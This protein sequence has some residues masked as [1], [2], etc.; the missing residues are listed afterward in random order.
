MKVVFS[1]MLRSAMVPLFGVFAL[2]AVMTGC[3]KS[4][5]PTA[6]GLDELKFSFGLNIVDQGNGTV[7]LSWSGMNNEKDF[8][9]YNVYGAKSD[10][11]VSLEGSTIK[12][13]DDKGD[14][15][16]A[17]KASLAKMGY[18]GKDWET[19]APAT[20]PDGD[21]AIYPYYTVTNGTD[22]VLPSCM[23]KTG[24]GAGVACDAIAAEGGASHVFNGSTTIDM[25]G[26]KIGSNYC[27][28]TLSTLDDGKKVA[29]TTSEVRCV[30][31]RAAVADVAASAAVSKAFAVDLDG[32][33]K[34]CGT[35]G[36]A[37]CGSLDVTA[38]ALANTTAVSFDA[39]T[40]CNATTTVAA[41]IEYFGAASAK[42]ANFTAGKNTGVQDLG[43]Y[44]NGFDDATLPKAPKLS[45]FSTLQN[46]DGYSV[47]GQSLPLEDK[48]MYV[49]GTA[50]P[51]DTTSPPTK[52][53]YH[54]IYVT[55]MDNDANTAATFKMTVRVSNKVDS[56]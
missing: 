44:A 49:V 55:G 31:P 54:F 43:Y 18:N 17:G 33:R 15:D 35:E 20:S 39:V 47:A 56:L 2:G 22:A 52:F 13:L 11:L 48:H 53:Y 32:L 16:P 38:D 7:R 41:C 50:D 46:K 21:L 10:E 34:A 1:K 36:G 51:T 12:L 6:V 28:T 26:L 29:Q 25:K 40:S 3:G 19:V 14:P 27:F 5:D 8:S 42:K 30:V 37:A 23:P 24:E 4:T 9:G 45:A